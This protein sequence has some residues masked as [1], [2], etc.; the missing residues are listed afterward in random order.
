M[1]VIEFLHQNNNITKN[2]YKK[3]QIV[4]VFSTEKT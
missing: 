3:I 1:F 4:R 2:G